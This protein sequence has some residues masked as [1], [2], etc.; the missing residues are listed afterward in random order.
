MKFSGFND[1]IKLNKAGDKVLC[2][3][4]K[5]KKKGLACHLFSSFTNGDMCLLPRV[6]T[7]VSLSPRATRIL[8]P[9]RGVRE[10]EQEPQ[11]PENVALNEQ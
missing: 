2:P 8:F 3:M 9:C 6:E 11:Q 5:K 10:T 4:L 7:W 1:F